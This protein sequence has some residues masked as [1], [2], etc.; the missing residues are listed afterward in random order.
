[1]N[2]ITNLHM[3]ISCKNSINVFYVFFPL[4]AIFHNADRFLNLKRARAKISTTV[5]QLSRDFA[6]AR[7]PEDFRKQNK[8]NKTG[9]IQFLNEIY[10]RKTTFKY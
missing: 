8:I 9:N 10:T 1:M 2:K 5:L 6:Q 7:R 3:I 4:V